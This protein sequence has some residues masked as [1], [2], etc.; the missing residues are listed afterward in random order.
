MMYK[1]NSAGR[2]GIYSHKRINKTQAEQ[3]E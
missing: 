2:T 3:I 1:P